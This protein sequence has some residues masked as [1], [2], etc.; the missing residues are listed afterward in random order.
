MIKQNIIWKT[1]IKKEIDSNREKCSEL[2]L[3]QLQVQVRSTFVKSKSRIHSLVEVC[4][5]LL[6]YL[7]VEKM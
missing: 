5:L 4:R 7:K 6:I 2:I 3:R 1:K